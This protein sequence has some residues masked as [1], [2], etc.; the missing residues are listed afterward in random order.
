MVILAHGILW[1]TPLW[2]KS[3]RQAQSLLEEVIQAVVSLLFHFIHKLIVILGFSKSEL[4]WNILNVAT[5]Y[6]IYY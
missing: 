5:S 2:K 3:W 1:G 6:L 4:N